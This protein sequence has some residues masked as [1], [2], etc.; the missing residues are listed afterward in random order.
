MGSKTRS[1]GPVLNQRPT[2][3]NTL[4][5][6]NY[7]KSQYFELFCL[8]YYPHIFFT[9]FGCRGNQL[10]SFTWTEF[11]HLVEN[12]SRNISVK[13]LSIH[14]IICSKNSLLSLFPLHVYGNL[15]RHSDDS[16]PTMAMQNTIF[17]GAILICSEE[18]FYIYFFGCHGNQSNSFAWTDVL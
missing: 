12:Y 16:T 13:L 9:F 1:L 4:T 6:I 14:C 3:H 15:R 8:K 7:C 18:M 17:P 5:W 10:D 11:I 2:G